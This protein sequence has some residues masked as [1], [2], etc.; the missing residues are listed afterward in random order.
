[1]GDGSVKA[2]GEIRNPVKKFILKIMEK[3]LKQEIT[4]TDE[5]GMGRP[6][7]VY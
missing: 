5:N 3:V 7:I 4:K 1:L 6:M 2:Y